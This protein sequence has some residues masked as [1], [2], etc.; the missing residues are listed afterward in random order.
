M[1]QA[2]TS[3]TLL[4]VDDDAAV[5]HAL[6]FA[7][8]LEGFRVAA[9]ASPLE[10]LARPPAPA[11]DC[12]IIDH[13]LPALTGLDVVEMMRR[14]GAAARPAIL[15]TSNPSGAVRARADAAGVPI[16]EKPLQSDDLMRAVR[17]IFS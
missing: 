8:E 3:R 5:R 1:A 12:L 13:R 15:I 17:R 2:F 14:D 9:F 7:L 4:I 10:L 11:F 16:V 6:Q